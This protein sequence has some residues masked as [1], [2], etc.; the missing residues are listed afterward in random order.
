MILPRPENDADGL[1]G[2]SIG[3][4]GIIVRLEEVLIVWLEGEGT[5][6]EREGTEGERE[7]TE[8]E[9]EGAAGQHFSA[10]VEAVGTFG[11][12]KEGTAELEEEGHDGI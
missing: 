10:R 8:G 4:L 2:I 1:V 7:G 6:G 11:L 5:E 9:G 12:D 3:A